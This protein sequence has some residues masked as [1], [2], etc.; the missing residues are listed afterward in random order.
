[1]TWLILRPTRRK[2]HKKTNQESAENAYKPLFNEKYDLLKDIFAILHIHC[3]DCNRNK[4][5]G[6]EGCKSRIKAALDPL[7]SSARRQ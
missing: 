4:L 1:M 5:R 7:P 2:K 3:G 6:V